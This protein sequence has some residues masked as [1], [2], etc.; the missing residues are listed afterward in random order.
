[1][2]GKKPAPWSCAKHGDAG[3][4]FKLHGVY[5]RC[6]EEL[7]GPVDG[8]GSTR[9]VLDQFL[10]QSTDETDPLSEYLNCEAAALAGPAEERVLSGPDA[11]RAS[12]RPYKLSPKKV[13]V[14][15]ARLFEEKTWQQ[16]AEEHGYGEASNAAR[17]F[18]DAMEILKKKGYRA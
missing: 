12:L 11:M 2:S 9:I 4:Y 1:M 13:E 5:C 14:I 10:H 7:I 3:A 17:A 6:L 8:G 15:I 18:R 16:I